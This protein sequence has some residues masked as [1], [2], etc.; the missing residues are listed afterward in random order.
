MKVGS[1]VRGDAMRLV[2]YL[3]VAFVQFVQKPACASGCV[4]SHAIPTE[5]SPKPSLEVF[6]EAKFDLT[7]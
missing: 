2:L 7:Y 6:S 4:R 3:R 5:R 1:D